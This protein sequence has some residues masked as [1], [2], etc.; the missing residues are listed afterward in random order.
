[1]T[2]ETIVV[3]T[4]LGVVLLA[5]VV[6][7]FARQRPDQVSTKVPTMGTPFQTTP[8][9]WTEGETTRLLATTELDRLYTPKS[10]YLSR[11]DQTLYLLLRAAVP[12]HNVVPKA[13]LG[14]LIQVKIGPQGMERLRLFRKAANVSVSFA[15]CDRNWRIV[16]AVDLRDP[17]FAGDDRQ[18]RLEI[19]KERCLHAARLRYLVV[20][21]TNLPRYPLLRQMLLGDLPDEVAEASPEA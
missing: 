8:D 3:V 20:E 9:Y 10:E 1:M 4:V 18:R 7:V 6:W 21:P 11:A 15:V 5:A 2:T 13:R 16:A 17:E 12:Q 19:V 14:D